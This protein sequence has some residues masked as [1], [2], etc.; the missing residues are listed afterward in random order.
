MKNSIQEKKHKQFMKLLKEDYNTVESLVTLWSSWHVEFTN[1]LHL[2]MCP[3]LYS[4]NHSPLQSRIAA[5]RDPELQEKLNQEGEA[6][7]QELLS[8][9]KLWVEHADVRQY[10]QQLQN[11]AIKCNSVLI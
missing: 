9:I 1:K 7:Y 3:S 8:I 2:D 11:E 5:K 10:I 4:I 6:Y